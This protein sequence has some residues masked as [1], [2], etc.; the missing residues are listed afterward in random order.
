MSNV[1]SFSGG[2]H[3][4]PQKSLKDFIHHAKTDLTMYD[5]SEDKWFVTKGAKDIP[6][7]FAKHGSSPYKWDLFDQ[8]FMDF[9]KAYI[10]EVQTLD[11]VTSRTLDVVALRYIFDALEKVTGTCDI[12]RV[13]GAVILDAANHIDAR[14]NVKF[15]QYQIG[16]KF[17]NILNF[18]RSKAFICPSLPGFVAKQRWKKPADKAQR[19]DAEGK[20]HREE[21]LPSDHV[22]KQFIYAFRLA[23]TRMD[24]YWASVGMLLLFAPN[25]S[26]EF[27]FLSINSLGW[28][29]YEDENGVIQKKMFIRWFSEKGQDDNKKWVFSWFEEALQ[30]A[31]DTL[32]EISEPARAAAK[33]AYDN[34]GRYMVHEY[35]VTPDNHPPNVPLTDVELA[36]ATGLPFLLNSKRSCNGEIY[37]SVRRTTF[38]KF[39][40]PFEGFNP[41][42]AQLAG[43]VVSQ[44]KTRDWPKHRR[45]CS[46]PV[47]ENLLLI[48]EFE[49]HADFTVKPFSWILPNVNQINRQLGEKQYETRAYSQTLFERLNLTDENGGKIEIDSHDLRRWHATRAMQEG[50]TELE[51]AWHAGRKDLSQNRS[52]DLRTPEQIAN[53]LHEI[54]VQNNSQV[55]TRHQ[56]PL[57]ER[58]QWNLPLHRS[59][60]IK[61]EVGHNTVHIG[62]MGGCVKHVTEPDCLKGRQCHGCSKHIIVKGVPGCL[63]YFIEEERR[64]QFQWDQIQGRR[65]DPFMQRT[66]MHVGTDLGFVRGRRKILEDPNV[67]DGTVIQIPRDFD[68]S[69]IR[70]GLQEQGMQE[71]SK[72]GP[73]MMTADIARLLPGVFKDAQESNY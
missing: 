3:E 58:I 70:L 2:N 49:F 4:N 12:T 60:L 45:Q 16:A 53:R 43:A 32:I 29:D 10:R 13:S 15:R 11:E 54:T 63:D 28:D 57:H 47:W 67:P 46:F 44:Y 36:H 52:Y 24:R 62:A 17:E 26:G 66:V 51:I 40:K 19:T 69:E 72:P 61:E 64:L 41:T 21:R 50:A 73:N 39:L 71:V 65:E 9:A 8:P 31:F 38:P 55:I 48:R 30:D 42:Y 37:D 1:I 35:C 33:F 27:Q 59:D 68:P 56:I 20:K 5:W 6:L 25:R 18:L 22:M 34:L 14:E 7:L 23:E